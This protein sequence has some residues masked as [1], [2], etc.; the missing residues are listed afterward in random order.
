MV[1]ERRRLTYLEFV[2]LWG[3]VGHGILYDR[4]YSVNHHKTQS[5]CLPF[6]QYIHKVTP[7]LQIGTYSTFRFT[8]LKY[9]YSW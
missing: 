8:D 4:N 2:Y 6:S 9:L 1:A 5:L 7:R 3:S